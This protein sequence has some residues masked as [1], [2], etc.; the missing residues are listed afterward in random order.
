MTDK[1]RDVLIGID[2]GTSVIK[3]VGFDL[4]GRQLGAAAVPNRY[5]T[6]A[7]G[8]ATQDMART[9]DDCAA[10]LRG[11]ADHIPNLAGRTAAGRVPGRPSR[12]SAR[13]P[14]ASTVSAARAIP[15]PL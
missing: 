8:A 6:G 10:A 4:S 13:W 1:Q 2:A 3:A 14:R 15:A 7:Q 5:T 12:Q 9:W 11:L